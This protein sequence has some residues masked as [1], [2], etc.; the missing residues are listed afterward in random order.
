MK[1]RTFQDDTVL[2]TGLDYLQKAFNL[3]KEFGIGDFIVTFTKVPGAVITRN[4]EYS[5]AGYAKF[6]WTVCNTIFQTAKQKRGMTAQ[7]QRE[8]ALTLARPTTSLGII[9]TGA[10]LASKGIIVGSDIDDK[11]DDN[12][13]LKK[14]R[15]VTGAKG[16]KLNWD[17]LRRYINGEDSDIK[18]G[19]RLFDISWAPFAPQLLVGATMQR[20]QGYDFDGFKD[21]F[22]DWWS[23]VG[24][25]INPLNMPEVIPETI[26]YTLEQ[27]SDLP[28]LQG[29]RDVIE[30][31]EYREGYVDFAIQLGTNWGLSFEPQMIRKLG[32]VLDA[33]VRDPYHGETTW[34]RAWQNIEAN[35]PI[36][37][38]R[39]NVPEQINV[40]G[41]PVSGTLGS[42][43]KDTLNEMLS[44]GRVS[45]FEESGLMEEL[46][47][48]YQY[49]DDALLKTPRMNGNTAMVEEKTVKFDL[50]GEDYEEY[51]KWLGTTTVRNITEFMKSD[52]YK[53]LPYYQRAAAVAKIN[54]E[55]EE[56]CRT[57]WAEMLCEADK[58]KQTEILDSGIESYQEMAKVYVRVNQAKDYVQKGEVKIEN[59]VNCYIEKPYTEA[60]KAEYIRD[61]KR[62]KYTE[63]EQ[64]LVEKLQAGLLK[65]RHYIEGTWSELTEEEQDKV[66]WY[67][68]QYPEN[69]VIPEELMLPENLIDFSD[70]EPPEEDAVIDVTNGYSRKKLLD[71]EETQTD[72]ATSQ[73]TPTS[74]ASVSS[75]K[76]S[77]G[78][79]SG[80]SGGKSGRKSSGKKSSGSKSRASKSPSN[81]GRYYSS[82]ET[83]DAMTELTDGIGY[84]GNIPLS[85]IGDEQ[86]FK[87]PFKRQFKFKVP[88]KDNKKTFIY[89]FDKV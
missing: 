56:A 42:W 6:I 10:M 80:K 69:V 77:S 84:P 29:I 79:S 70:E 27:M 54:K 37:P 28:A 25:M 23:S 31:W 85:F 9:A 57:A 18:N 36:L 65:K 44:P 5:P 46:D 16:Y 61:K 55:S 86:S 26:D 89:P 49:N 64:A 81:I 35:L 52:Y 60:E 12:Y 33:S 47:I 3:R 53:Y 38:L 78:K 41:E 74:S 62:G 20:E 7:E 48:L 17:G 11:D 83:A 24:Y 66:L 59:V 73:K 15:S 71:D 75:A 13:L 21:G 63:N 30:S 87:H 39:K 4:L 8:F 82:I 45:V 67:I 1:Y 68:E 50:Y 22:H 19:D 51:S 14:F 32:N 88:F 58:A 34:I 76:S 40:F 72:K 43:W 2:G